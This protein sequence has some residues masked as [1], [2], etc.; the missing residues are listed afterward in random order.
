VIPLPDRV[1]YEAVMSALSE[2]LDSELVEE[3]HS[4]RLVRNSKGRLFRPDQKKAWVRFQRSGR[5]LC[6]KYENVCMLTTD[7]TSYF[8]FI[9][10]DLLLKELRS[11]PNVSARLVDL[12]ARVLHGFSDVTQLNGIPQGPEVSSFLG[13]FYLRPL[14]AILRKLDVRFTRF[15]DDI[16]VFA[17]ERHV[18]RKAIHELTPVIRARRL[19]LSSAKTKILEGAD[20]LGHFEDARKDAIQ[21]RIEIED[22]TVVEDLRELFD[23][24]VRAEVQERDLKF[25]VYRLGK[26]GDDHAVPWIL[27]HLADVPYLSELLVRYLSL[28]ATNQPEIEE[29]VVA[30][31]KDERSNIIPYVEMQLV[32]MFA[33]A[34]E[35]QEPTYG[36][37]WDILLNPSSDSQSRQFAARAIGRHLNRGRVADLELLRGVFHRNAHDTPLRR[38]LLV[39]LKEAGDADKAFLD[40]VAAG[41]PALRYVCRYLRSNPKL[42]PP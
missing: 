37:L 30:F 14:D 40:G 10:L 18:L 38:A 11:V 4:A 1:V 35:I 7:I 26:L 15:Q 22:D 5:E 33:N 19:N 21:Y 31:L 24:A 13:N 28:H 3:V 36:V 9:D 2:T 16:K 17:H 12:L 23:H 8:E 32:R 42:P 27:D 6:E 41:D 25:A 29:P 34:A 39:G 20:V